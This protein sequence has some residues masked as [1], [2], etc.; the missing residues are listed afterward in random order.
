MRDFEPRWQALAA[1]ARRAQTPL[2]QMPFGFATRVLARAAA[3]PAETVED[4]LGS[5][6][7]RAL[8]AACVLCAASAAYACADMLDTRLERPAFEQTLAEE[9]SWP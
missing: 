1:D 2:P 3:A 8:L 6:S 7:L 4:I 9:L 5:L